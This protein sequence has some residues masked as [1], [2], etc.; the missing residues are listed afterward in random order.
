MKGEA[1]AD[2]MRYEGCTDTVC[3]PP[4]LSIHGECL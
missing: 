1:P 3:I 4:Y 2:L